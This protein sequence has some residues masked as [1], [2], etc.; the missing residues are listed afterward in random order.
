VEGVDHRCRL[1]LVFLQASAH[2]ARVALRPLAR[3]LRSLVS[4]SRLRR[5][6]GWATL[7]MAISGRRSGSGARQ[8]DLDPE[9]GG[10]DAAGTVKQSNRARSDTTLSGSRLISD[11]NPK[12]EGRVG[13]LEAQIYSN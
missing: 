9:L 2:R 3:S 6:H 4:V 8:H 10:R 1:R 13:A 12:H 11:D 7:S 5:V